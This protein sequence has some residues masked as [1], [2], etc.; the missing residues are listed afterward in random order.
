MTFLLP[1]G[2]K[3]LTFV[4]IFNLQEI[5]ELEESDELSSLLLE[6]SDD[7]E[8]ELSLLL[9]DDCCPNCWAITFTLGIVFK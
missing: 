2:I 7:E 4:N 8:E 6:E 3:R 9:D 1:P 5:P